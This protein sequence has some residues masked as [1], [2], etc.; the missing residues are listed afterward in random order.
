MI[1]TRLNDE[2]KN[3]TLSKK[4]QECIK[5]VKENDILGTFEPGVYELEKIGVKMIYDSYMSKNI[6]DT[7]WESHKKYIDIQIMLDGE[8]YIG[9]NKIE[10]MTMVEENE[11]KDYWLYKGETLFNVPIKNGDLVVL[12]P[13]DV[14]MPGLKINQNNPNKKLVF[15]VEVDKL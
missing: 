8:E 1:F 15:K 5:Y 3:K 4:V 13:E 11:E 10:N 9:I 6:E 14:H 12:Y 7:V 2:Q